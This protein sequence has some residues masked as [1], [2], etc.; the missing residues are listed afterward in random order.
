MEIVMLGLGYRSFVSVCLLAATSV[1]PAAVLLS[2]STSP[3]YVMPEYALY[4]TCTLDD[5]GVLTMMTQLNGLTSKRTVTGQFGLDGIRQNIAESVS[6]HIKKPEF[7]IADLA[8]TTYSASHKQANG[9]MINVFLYEDSGMQNQN[10]Y[11]ESPAALAL[12]NFMDEI[13]K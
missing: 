11:N 13:C 7:M 9:Q 3:G 4:T 6:G 1:V 10:T 8:S 2:K 5:K 12:R